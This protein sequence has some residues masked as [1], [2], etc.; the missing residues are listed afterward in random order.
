MLIKTVHPALAALVLGILVQPFGH[1]QVPAPPA[2]PAPSAF[3]PTAVMPLDAAVTTGTLPNGLRYYVRQNP[4]P[5]KRVMLQLAVKAGSVDE[6]DAQQGLAHFLE[7]MGFNGTRRFKPGELIAD[8]RIDRRAPRPARQRPDRL[9]R[10]DLHVPAA[11]RQGGHRRK[12]DGGARR[13]RRWHDARSEGDRQGTRGRRRR[14]ARGTRRRV[15]PAG[16]ADPG[17]LCQVEVRR[18]AADRQARDPQDVSSRRTACLLHQVVPSRPHGGRGGR[19]H[20]CGG[21]RSA[22]QERIRP[23][24][25][26]VDASPGARLSDAPAAGDAGEDGD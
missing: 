25:E 24:R 15:A 19:R 23:T 10:H 5:E 26:A 18:T 8:A 20:A 21:T 16:S 4:R 17:A 12:R 7:H 2:P 1:A 9:R 3:A 11:H 13:L 14:M 22:H 6:T